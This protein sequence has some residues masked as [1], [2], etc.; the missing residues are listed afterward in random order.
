MENQ[1]PTENATQ[2]PASASSPKAPAPTSSLKPKIAVL[3]LTAIFA[4]I[5]WILSMCP[6]K[7]PVEVQLTA[8]DIQFNIADSEE[9]E[10]LTQIINGISLKW[11][12]IQSYESFDISP[13]IIDT[14]SVKGSKDRLECD[15]PTWR[16]YKR[17]YDSLSY[18]PS[19]SGL[20]YNS[21]L[22]LTACG[23][24][25]LTLGAIAAQSGSKVTLRANENSQPGVSLIIQVV[26]GNP[27]NYITF[28]NS[29]TLWNIWSKVQGRRG[30]ITEEV[31]DLSAPID[32]IKQTKM[33]FQKDDKKSKSAEINGVNGALSYD[34]APSL[35][36]NTHSIT[37]YD[38][39]NVIAH[40]E[41]I[42]IPVQDFN[43]SFQKHWKIKYLR[44]L[45]TGKEKELSVSNN[46]KDDSLQ[47]DKRKKY[48]VTGITWNEDNGGKRLTFTL[49]GDD[50]NDLLLE[51]KEVDVKFT[52]LDYLL[53]SAWLALIAPII[54]YA[55][56]LLYDLFK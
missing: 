11:A 27:K 46:V 13:S 18:T 15:N 5:L 21:N 43:A 55:Y 16:P 20:S 51:S 39:K 30:K 17:Q 12:G 7:T 52:V 4:V 14:P 2:N 53:K 9:K 33:T 36:P 25:P 6:L 32:E 8:N 28:E 38:H 24:A 54:S 22:T 34:L 42:Y 49:L 56:K 3:A 29:A 35:P 47:L 48:S 41:G 50:A 23:K 44:P 45:F 26:K 19:Q 1:Q 40:K 10:S 31:G 37:L